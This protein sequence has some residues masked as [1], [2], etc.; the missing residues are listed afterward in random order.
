MN[1]TPYPDRAILLFIACLAA[2][3]AF[4]VMAADDTASGGTITVF[5]FP[6]GAT[7]ELSGEYRGVTPLVL[8]HVPPGEYL[9]NLTLAGF[10]NESFTLTLSHGSTR[11]IGVN[12]ENASIPAGLPGNGSVAIDSRPGGAIVNLDGKPVG[13]T[14]DGRAA[15]ILN[16]VPAGAHAVTVVRAGYPVYAKTVTVVKNRVVR[17]SADLEDSAA[18]ITETEDH[19]NL[20]PSP[21][22]GTAGSPTPAAE[23]PSGPKPAATTGPERTG[24]GPQSVP[25][26]LVTPAIAAA[27]AGLGVVFRR[28]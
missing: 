14:P 20:P 12:L 17:V 3:A 28:S 25:Q 16:S 15:L 21:F 24:S 23:S 1:K 4:P 11:E 8:E 27:L 5:S 26:S 10:R 22:T 6:S 9:L 13:K 19:E 2:G 7:V 18:M